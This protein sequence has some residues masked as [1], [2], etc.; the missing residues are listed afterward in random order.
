MRARI[1]A[2]NLGLLALLCIAGCSSGSAP[3]PR[4]E[5]RPEPPPRREPQD[6]ER[7]LPGAKL[8]AIAQLRN[9]LPLELTAGSKEEPAWLLVDASY[10]KT[11]EGSNA[12]EIAYTNSESLLNV[13]A[14]EYPSD[15]LARE[16]YDGVVARVSSASSTKP[17][18]IKGVERACAATLAERDA[19]TDRPVPHG[20]ALA[21]SGR[22]LFMFD[23]PGAEGADAAVVSRFVE[24]CLDV[25]KPPAATQEPAG[26]GGG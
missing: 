6:G 10:L 21:V 14:I 8:A 2:R 18:A 16:R 12:W 17:L 5:K 19:A 7:V 22:F 25:L 1:P 26:P 23:R 15:A 20:I 13:A 24:H 9:N 11:P 3:P 4:P